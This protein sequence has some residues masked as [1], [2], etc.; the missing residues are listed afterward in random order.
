MV[1]DFK[2]AISP[3][4]AKLP[5]SNRSMYLESFGIAIW[6]FFN[7]SVTK[8]VWGHLRATYRSMIFFQCAISAVRFVVL[9]LAFSHFIWTIIG[10]GRF[11]QQLSRSQRRDKSI[12]AEEMSIITEVTNINTPR[13]YTRKIPSNFNRG[14]F[15]T[16]FSIHISSRCGRAGL[17]CVVQ[18]I[19]GNWESL[20]HTIITD[21]TFLLL[22][23]FGQ[24]MYRWLFTDSG[25]IVGTLLSILYR[26]YGFRFILHSQPGLQGQWGD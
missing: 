7:F 5:I 3:R 23:A 18:H 20:S 25:S 1:G 6:K 15:I 19:S 24:E 10:H 11:N 13:R 26:A 14:G 16:L 2:C 8:Q 9:V 12:S 4:D 21:R 17:F 22:C